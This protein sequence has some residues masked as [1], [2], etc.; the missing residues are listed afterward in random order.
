MP[1]LFS[2]RNDAEPA[3]CLVRVGP[4]DEFVQAALTVAVGIRDGVGCIIGIESMG[5]LPVVRHAVMI[6]I[7]D[8][9]E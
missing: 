4:G 2:Q 9:P 8:S 3:C 1:V 6:C 7:G 5:C